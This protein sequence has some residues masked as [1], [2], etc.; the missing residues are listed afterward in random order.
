MAKEKASYPKKSIQIAS[1]NDMDR[2]MKRIAALFL[3]K[4]SEDNWESFDFALKNVK[5]WASSDKI[6]QYPG[7]VDHLKALQKP[8]NSSLASERT[9]LST[10]AHDLLLALAKAMQRK[11][12]LV[13]DLFMPTLIQLF[14]RTNKV[15]ARNTLA[16]VKSIIECSKMPRVL[17]PLCLQLS[18]NKNQ[19]VRHA[20]IECICVVLQVNTGHDLARHIDDLE[21]SIKATAM[22]ASPQ[23]RSGIRHCYKLYSQKFP[24]RVSRFNATLSTDTAK[25]L[26]ILPNH[27]AS[28]SK[29]SAS[30]GSSS[31][32]PTSQ[33][34]SSA[35][36]GRKK[37][38]PSTAT[39]SATR[40]SFSAR[41]SDQPQKSPST[42]S[43]TPVA[44]ISKSYLAPTAASAAKRSTAA[45]TLAAPSPT[46]L[47]QKYIGQSTGKR[48]R[49]GFRSNT[50]VLLQGGLPA[51]RVKKKPAS[52]TPSTTLTKR[53]TVDSPLQEEDINLKKFKKDV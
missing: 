17:R 27:A 50:S 43:S 42:R 13:N 49:P 1:K 48:L 3:K 4:E 23:V 15:H 18:K 8:I 29:P 28:G 6:H 19:S 11:Y 35:P 34:L 36:L 9:R 7:F 51:L 39:T 30:V 40:P 24:S 37:R 47:S 32:L 53:K 14:A 5:L 22:D 46:N 44:S 45:P 52:P 20:I 41:N 38:I 12:E 26:Q 25:Y 10:T 33:S 31:S 16:C 2:E 21:A